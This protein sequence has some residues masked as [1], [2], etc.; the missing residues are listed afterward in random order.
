LSVIPAKAGIQNG[1]K[2]LD[3]ESHFALNTMRGRASLARNDDS[4]IGQEFCDTLMCLRISILIYFALWRLAFIFLSV[5]CV[6]SG[7][8]SL[9]TAARPS[10]TEIPASA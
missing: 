4:P 10:S 3:S 9:P 5:L 8:K 7:E 2:I 1:W 6:L